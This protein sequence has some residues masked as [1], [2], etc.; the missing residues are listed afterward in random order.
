MRFW[1]VVNLMC[2]AYLLGIL[3]TDFLFDLND[4]HIK[5]RTYYCE[6]ISSFR[7][8][9]GIVRM[10]PVVLLVISALQSIYSSRGTARVRHL[11]S[12][13]ILFLNSITLSVSVG[14]A[15]SGC[16]FTDSWPGK[17]ILTAHFAMFASICLAIFLVCSGE[18]SP[19]THT[20]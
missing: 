15:N 20:G 1:A 6:M 8:F 4:D 7:A 10:S 17:I 16:L 9:S 14:F 18:A 13:V 12:A 3:S 5:T 11:Q 2:L 19:K